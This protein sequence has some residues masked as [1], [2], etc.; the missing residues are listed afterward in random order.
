MCDLGTLCEHVMRAAAVADLTQDAARNQR[1]NLAGR[2]VLRNLADFRP[3]GRRQI[4]REP[5]QKTVQHSALVRV[6][7]LLRMGLPERRLSRMAFSRASAASTARAWHPTNHAIHRVTSSPRAGRVR[8]PRNRHPSPA[9]SA[10]AKSHSFNARASR[11]LPSS[12]GCRVRKRRCASAA[13]TS[14][15]RAKGALSASRKASISAGSRS[16]GGA[17]K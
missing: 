15:G 1:S 10:R 8:A 6:Q 3:L 5:V 12:N 11:P 17:W 14:G 9:G 4:A 16:A 7:I 13:V 2:G